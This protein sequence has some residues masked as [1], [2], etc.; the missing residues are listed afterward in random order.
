MAIKEVKKFIPMKESKDARPV[1][2][3]GLID[4]ADPNDIPYANTPY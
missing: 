4:N 1:F 2:F 3:G